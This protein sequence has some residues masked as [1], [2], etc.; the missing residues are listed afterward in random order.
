MAL[1]YIWGANLHFYIHGHTHHTHTLK[2]HNAGFWLG[3]VDCQHTNRAK[4][5]EQ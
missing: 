2:Y 4:I 5:T 1:V 3:C